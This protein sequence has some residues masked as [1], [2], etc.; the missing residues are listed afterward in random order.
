MGFCLLEWLTL[1]ALTTVE[2]LCKWK[3]LAY[4]EATWEDHDLIAEKA[5][6]KI[7]NYLARV[8]STSVPAKSATYPRGRP[9]FTKLSAQ[10][11][12]MNE[13]GQLKEFQITGL[14]WLT[15]LWCRNENGI[16]ADEMYVHL[17]RSSFLQK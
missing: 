8:A 3:G 1:S 7:D 2:Y 16:L 10:P 17:C 5:Q 12:Y 9:A 14:N 11:D 6:D 13:C 15:Y 4:S